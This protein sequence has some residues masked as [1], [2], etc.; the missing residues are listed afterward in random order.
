MIHA[1]DVLTVRPGQLDEVHRRVREEY[2]PLVESLD[3]RL[4]HSWM[5][6][7]VELLDRPTELLFLWELPDVAAFWRIRRIAA[8][9]LRVL[10]FWDDMTPLLVTRERKLMCDPDDATVLR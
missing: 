10:A 7:A 1:L 6:P 5:S 2:A 8:Q 4:T 3:M 9:D